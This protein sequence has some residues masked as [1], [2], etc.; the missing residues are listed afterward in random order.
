MR[1]NY[2]KWKDQ[3]LE[4]EVK[5]IKRK[6]MESYGTA[7]QIVKKEHR[8]KLKKEIARIKTILNERQRE[9]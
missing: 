4:L 9:K 2:R 6:L 1:I 3:D 7:K 8:T 5:K